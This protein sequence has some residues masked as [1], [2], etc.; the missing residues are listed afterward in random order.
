MPIGLFRIIPIR[1]F[2]PVPGA[3]VPPAGRD[4]PATATSPTVRMVCVSR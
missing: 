3:F 2:E 1:S 4:Q